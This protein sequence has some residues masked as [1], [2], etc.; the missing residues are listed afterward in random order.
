VQRIT[1]PGT[2]LALPRLVF[3]TAALFNL[4]GASA[5]ARLLDAAVDHGFTHFDTA[6]L[7][8]FGVAE[9]ELGALL[10]R[11]PGVTITTKAG[12]YAPG[13]EDQPR[14]A[15]FARKALG[16][17]LPAASAVRVDLAV[18]RAERSLA[19]SLRRLGTDHLALFLVHELD[20]SALDRAGWTDW[21]EAERRR[22]R[23]GAYGIAARAADLPAIVVD[24][25]PLAAIVQAPDSLV[26]REAEPLLR[27]GRPLQLSYG[28][29]TSAKSVDPDADVPDVLAAA[30][31]RNATGAVLVSTRRVERL[32][33]LADAAA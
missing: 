18:A 17:V 21:L 15:V 4:R 13:G 7:Y 14:A 23:I 24:A 28:Y 8:G 16:R 32:R 10:R 27:A 2:D 22:G 11:H 26:A 5:R 29:V 6:P 19:A 9:R 1:L 25:A 3:G 12:R 31:R 30:L 33:A 20:W